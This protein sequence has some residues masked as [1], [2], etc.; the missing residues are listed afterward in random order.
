MEV[1]IA[2]SLIFSLRHFGVVI[3]F[4]GALLVCFEA[5]AGLKNLSKSFDPGWSCREYGAACSFE[6]FGFTALLSNLSMW[7]LEYD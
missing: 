5:A 6:V 4:L 2:I 7:A 3:K 1:E